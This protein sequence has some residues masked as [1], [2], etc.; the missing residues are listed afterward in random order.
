MNR[1]K[2]NRI[3]VHVMKSK[4]IKE[5]QRKSNNSHIELNKITQI[6][7]IIKNERNFKRSARKSPNILIWAEILKI[8]RRLIRSMRSR[9]SYSVAVAV[10]PETFQNQMIFF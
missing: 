6:G 1:I 3:T 10:T 7:K 8:R 9:I 5:N 2:L 4:E